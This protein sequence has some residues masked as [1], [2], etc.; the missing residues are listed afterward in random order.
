MRLA[1]LSP[2]LRGGNIDRGDRGG[3]GAEV[4]LGAAGSEASRIGGTGREVSGGGGGTVK[5]GEIF[6]GSAS[7]LSSGAPLSRT[8]FSSGF[9]SLSEGNGM[10]CNQL[11]I[12]IHERYKVAA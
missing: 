1:G 6:T 7:A 12:P 9:R 5:G 2:G 11:D 3:V 10:D 4:S 8:S